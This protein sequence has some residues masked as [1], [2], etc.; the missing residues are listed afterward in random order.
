MTDLP[1]RLEQA[2]A[3]SRELSDEVLLALG[4]KIW[5][6]SRL[7]AIWRSPGPHTD[8]DDGWTYEPPDPTRSVDDGLAPAGDDWRSILELAC[9]DV[10]LN[11]ED[12]APLAKLPLFICAALVRAKAASNASDK[13]R[14]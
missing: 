11:H 13:P 7:V 1:A 4:W 5:A 12:P 6:G 14:G 8:E 3:G 2:A 10:W 9:I